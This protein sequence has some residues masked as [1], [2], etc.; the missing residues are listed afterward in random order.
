[1]RKLAG[2]AVL[3]GSLVGLSWWGAADHAARM[4]ERITQEAQALAATARH[5]VTAQV[6]GRDIT[7]TGTADSAAERDRLLAAYGAVDGR[8]VVRD[9]LTILPQ[10]DPFVITALRDDAGL[11]AEGMIPSEADRG[12]LAG[13]IGDLASGLTV[14]GGAPEGWTG[15]AGQ[16]LDALAALNTGRMELSGQVLTLS[17]LAARPA[18]RDAALAALADLPDGYSAET[19]IDVEDDG[20]PFSLNAAFDGGNINVQGKVPR[21]M[22][23]SLQ[24]SAGYVGALNGQLTEAR[25][26]DASGLW[27]GIGATGLAALGALSEGALAISDTRV[28]L[29]GAATPQGRARAEELLATLPEGVTATADI[30]LADDGAPFGLTVRKAPGGALS[31]AGKLPSDMDPGASGLPASDDLVIASAAAPDTAFADRVRAGMAGLALLDEGRLTVTRDALSLTGTAPDLT[32]RTDVL[33]ALG[34]FA[35]DGAEA[36][37]TV[38]ELPAGDAARDAGIST[39]FGLDATSGAFGI[40][41]PLL[42]SA[43]SGELVPGLSDAEAQT[44]TTL[45]GWTGELD[46]FALGRTDAVP[47]LDVTFAPGVSADQASAEL[48]D[49]LGGAAA[50]TVLEAAAPAE[51]TTRVNAL[52]GVRETYRFG[53]WLPELDFTPAPA[54][55]QQQSDSVLAAT[56]VNFLSGEATLDARSMRAINRLA[57][58]LRRC[59]DALSITA[60]LGGHTDSSGNA[61]ANQLLSQARAEAVRDALVARGVDAAML[62]ATGY[63][64]SQPVAD[65]ATAEGRAA[66]RRTTVTFGK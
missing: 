51:G 58:V 56:R 43:L 44:L 61:D 38:P 65:N 17:G 28:S 37:I 9:D 4:E 31:A 10:G 35:A 62:T 14:T 33:D 20:R 13:Q 54:T 11:S 30:T 47:D 34:L 64:A 16:G 48:T 26:D 25:I 55:C 50:L 40:P 46:A 32:T 41:D 66:N 7:L 49:E 6:A 29:T 1:M 36:A 52:T 8:R 24:A 53:A 3:A 42:R 22:Q 12:T 39:R 19:A 57:A 21:G 5:D 60:E 45:G 63:G 27:P 18:D 59:G 2:G 15:V 23:Q